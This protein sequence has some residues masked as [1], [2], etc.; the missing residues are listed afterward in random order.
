MVAVWQAHR[1]LVVL[2]G[3]RNAVGREEGIE[4]SRPVLCMSK[5]DV[6]SAK[7]DLPLHSGQVVLVSALV[8]DQH[9]QG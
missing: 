4:V 7:D 8:L 2:V 3:V 1:M 5:D 9:L 6:V